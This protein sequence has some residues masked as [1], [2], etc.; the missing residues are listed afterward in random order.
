MSQAIYFFKVGSFSHA[1]PRAKTFLAENFAGTRLV[2]VDVVDDLIMKS[3][4]LILAALWQVVVRYPAQV[5][6]AR[7]N[8]KDFFPRTPVV[9][10]RIK[11]WVARHVST[12]SCLFTFQTQSLFDASRPGVPHFLYTDHTHL[13]NLR[14]KNWVRPSIA[15]EDWLKIERTIYS[16]ALLNFTTS[17]FCSRSIIED[18]AIPPDRVVTVYSGG[19]TDQLPQVDDAAAGK[20]DGAVI[21]FV[22]VTWER[23]GGPELF[24]AFQKVVETCPQA[25]LWVV[26]CTPKICHPQCRI[27]G[28]VSLGEVSRIY[29]EASVFCLPS[30]HEPSAFALVEAASFGL[31]VVSTNVGGTPDRV[32]HGETGYVVEPADTAALAAALVELLQNPAKAREMGRRGRELVAERFTWKAVGVAI[33]KNIRRVLPAAAPA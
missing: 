16:Q 17:E 20:A 13:A 21:L 7:R 4:A 5:F 15:S 22:G 26:G 9:C 1:N 25:Q 6:L 19:N 14:Y 11:Q 30:R 24:E 29:R 28:R 31:P 23:K 8:P 12:E 3:P 10:R 27:F 2:V 32:L 18:Y 33:A